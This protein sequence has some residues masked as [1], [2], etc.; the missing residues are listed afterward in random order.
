MVPAALPARSAPIDVKRLLGLVPSCC[1][2]ALASCAV[3]EL[4]QSNEPINTASGDTNRRNL[5]TTAT[6]PPQ[7]IV[8]LGRT[9]SIVLRNPGCAKAVLLWV[10]QMQSEQVSTWRAT[11]L[12]P[13]GRR[14]CLLEM[15]S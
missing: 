6:T 12:P 3:A 5:V 8:G 14:I 2:S 7:V 10:K 9:R 4:K 15:A 13:R 11:S 1:K